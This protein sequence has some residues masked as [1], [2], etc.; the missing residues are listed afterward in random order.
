MQTTAIT[1]VPKAPAHIRGVVNIRG[2]VVTVMDLPRRFGYE[3]EGEYTSIIVAEAEVGDERVS[4]G[5]LADSITHVV[6]LT[7]DDMEKLPAVGS[8]ADCEY[9]LG[10][11]KLEDAFVVV[12]DV[13]AVVKKTGDCR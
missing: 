10:V 1:R 7:G 8:H 12:L 4:V 2:T 3:H 5:I 9:V 11:G 13:D 6:R